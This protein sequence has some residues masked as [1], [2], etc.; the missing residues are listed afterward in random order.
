MAKVRN[1]FVSNSSSSS[2]II[3]IAVVPPEKL[4]EIKTEYPDNIKSVIDLMSEEP[5]RWR[6]NMYNARYDCIEV[7]SFN[8]QTESVDSIQKLVNKDIK[9]HILYIDECGYEPDYDDDS[10]DYNYDDIDRDSEWFT[11]SQ[12]EL[13]DKIDELGGT[14]SV[15][16]GFNG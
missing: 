15:G 12:L 9:A 10:G 8:G 1:G 14:V 2:F 4:E 16:G 5:H 7:E 11:E 13:A 6:R 3:G